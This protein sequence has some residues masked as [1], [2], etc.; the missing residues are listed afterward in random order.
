MAHQWN[1]TKKKTIFAHPVGKRPRKEP[2]FGGA[3]QRMETGSEFD[4]SHLIA[5]LGTR[6][7]TAAPPFKRSCSREQDREINGLID[8]L[9][10]RTPS[11]ALQTIESAA[12]SEIGPSEGLSRRRAS[13]RPGFRGQFQRPLG[14]IGQGDSASR[15]LSRGISRLKPIE[16]FD[17][18]GAWPL[19]ML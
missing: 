5:A 1:K 3:L 2:L 10:T 16:S 13:H 7:R 18:G 4:R 8:V 12:G 19:E 11:A 14:S 6:H 9:A 17:P 15:R